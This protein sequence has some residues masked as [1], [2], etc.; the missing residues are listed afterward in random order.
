MPQM[1]ALYNGMGGAAAASIAAIEL[2][3]NHNQSVG[4]IVLAL[5]GAFIGGFSMSGSIIA[6]AKLQEILKNPVI[7]PKHPLI[8]MFL[9][10]TIVVFGIL[11]CLSNSTP[12]ILIIFYSLIMISG[13]VFTLPI[14]GANMPIV[15]SLFNALTGIAVSFNG[16][17]LNNNLLIV[18]GTVVGASGLM[19]THLMIKA[20]NKSLKDVLW[21]SKTGKSDSNPGVAS[22][23]EYNIINIQDASI[24]IAYANQI[25]IV[26]GYGMA[27]SQAHFKIAEVFKELHAKGIQVKFAI[28]PVA[29][30]MPGHMN[31]LLA[32]AGIPYEHIYDLEEIN[33]EFARSDVALVIGANDIVNP[34][35]RNQPD[36]PIYGMPILDALQAKQVYV[37]KRGHGRGFS[38]VENPLFFMDNVRMLIGNA[39]DVVH[40]LVQ[41]L[42]AEL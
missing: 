39:Q 30:R 1:I 28:H 15:I 36:S 10:G 26:P 27:V 3:H 35:A 13:I 5:F 38:N 37:I 41:N 9:A 18:A 4:P 11:L 16:L 20:M 2:I 31:V 17:S 23:G 40:Q 33:S 34:A 29:G 19:L 12:L 32:E 21:I 14:G 8:N 42:K 25:I 7:F 22:T 24:S 6:F